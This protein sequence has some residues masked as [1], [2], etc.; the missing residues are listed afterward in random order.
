MGAS[1]A[2]TSSTSSSSVLLFAG[3]VAIGSAVAFGAAYALVSHYSKQL[4]AARKQQGSGRYAAEH[5]TLVIPVRIYRAPL[6]HSPVR[7]SQH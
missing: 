7:A 3:G 4:D 2:S 6:V 1:S 5:K